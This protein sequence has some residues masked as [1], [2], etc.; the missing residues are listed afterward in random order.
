M[1]VFVIVHVLVFG[2]GEGRPRLARYHLA[3]LLG[4]VIGAVPCVAQ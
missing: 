3:P 2:S 4:A 1:L